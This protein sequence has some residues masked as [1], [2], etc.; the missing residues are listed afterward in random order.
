MNHRK[1]SFE[2]ALQVFDSRGV[3]TTGEA[4]KAGIH[5]R[6]LY[7]L[8]DQG[9]IEKLDRGLYGIKGLR[10]ISD[11]DLAVVAKKIPKG[12]L[13]LISALYFHRLTNQIPH[14]I[15]LAIPQKTKAPKVPYP[16]VK[17]Y[18]FSEKIWEI[19]IEQ[20]SIGNVTINCYS[21]EKTI[22]DCF[23]H[24]NKIG[25][26]VAIEAL[27]NYWKDGNTNLEKI[28]EFAKISKVDKVMQ[29]YLESVLN[30]DS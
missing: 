25:I 3:L 4:R 6:T 7:E 21:K 1:N 13:C 17:F 26:E 16:P 28:K 24:R 18:W 2:R 29:P 20:H 15:Y 14:Y 12:V 19:G 10:G 30:E 11:P 9:V 23:K 22:V 5:P 8:R 27:K